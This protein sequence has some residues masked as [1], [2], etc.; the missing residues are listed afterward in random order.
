MGGTVIANAQRNINDITSGRFEGDPEN[1][2][3]VIRMDEAAFEEIL[4]SATPLIRQHTT[5]TL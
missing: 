4:T 5:K 2:R 1:F 3:N